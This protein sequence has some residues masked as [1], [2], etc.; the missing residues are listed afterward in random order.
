MISVTSMLWRLLGVAVAAIA[1]GLGTGALVGFGARVATR[2]DMP[3]WLRRIFRLV[4]GA[5]MGFLAALGLLGN[6]G[7]WG[8][9]FGG[10]GTGSGTG[11]NGGT[12]ALIEK[13][14]PPSTAAPGPDVSL[15]EML[16]IEVLG[17]PALKRMQGSRFDGTRC[18]RIDITGETRLLTLP[19][20]EDLIR[21]R[22]QGSLPLRKVVL[23]LYNDSPANDVPRVSE[24]KRWIEEEVPPRPEGPIVV[25]VEQRGQNA[26][27][28]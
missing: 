18:Y 13:H 10:S 9:G 24:L 2:R 19:E 21:A 3:R 4:G 7:G 15:S 28:K 17:D 22:Q 20:V 14:E 1:G 27:A 26:P 11:T 25:D 8:F 5:A 23:T 16:Q 6:G 12:A